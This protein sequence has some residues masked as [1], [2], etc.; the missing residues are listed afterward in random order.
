MSKGTYIKT[1]KELKE[2]LE[3]IPDDTTAT[4]QDWN[5]VLKPFGITYNE[6]TNEVT[7]TNY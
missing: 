6:E 1:V 3:D 4:C 7:V 2:F 5:G